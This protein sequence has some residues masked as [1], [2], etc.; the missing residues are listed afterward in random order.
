MITLYAIL[1]LFS[2]DPSEKS[3]QLSL[4]TF[5]TKEECL[6]YKNSEEFTKQWAKLENKFLIDIKEY[7]V[8]FGCEEEQL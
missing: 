8:S 1:F 2:A 5:E 6:Q 4:K 3:L 7:R